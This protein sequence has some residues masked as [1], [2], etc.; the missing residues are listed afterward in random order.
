MTKNQSVVGLYIRVSTQEQ[1]REGYSIEEQKER[2]T[3]YAEAHSWIIGDVYSDPGFSGAKLERPSI[4]RLITDAEEH[5]I[6][7]VIVYKLDRL[8]RS[9]K[10]TLYLIEDVF[11]KNGVDFVSMTE[12]FDTGTPFGKAMIG[13]LSEFAQLER[14]QIK[15]RLTMGRVGRAKSGLVLGNFNTIT[16]YDYV[17]G[18]LVVNEYYTEI[19]RRIF[20][21]FVAGRS[22]NAVARDLNA[23]NIPTPSGYEWRGGNLGHLLQHRAYIGEVEYRGEVYPGEHEAI[24][25]RETFNAAQDRLEDRRLNDELYHRFSSRSSILTGLCWCTHCRAKKEILSGRKADGTRT[26]FIGCREKKKKNCPDERIPLEMVEEYVLTEIKKLRLDPE[27][28]KD[29]RKKSEAK[30]VK[31]QI[32]IYEERIAENEKK[33]KRLTDL[34]VVEG[35]DLA[36]LK[37]RVEQCTAENESNRERI[38]RLRRSLKEEIP[39]EKILDLVDLLDDSDEETVKAAVKALIKRI[40]FSGNTITINWTF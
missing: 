23:E 7:K 40:D 21:E 3:K 2:L 19:V 38:Q 16:G 36:T 25:D 17:D 30:P 10:D 11:L 14:E 6:D 37:E 28:L 15:E 34:Y 5:K 33:V 20:R 22:L 13:I 9:Q 12:N 4:R 31:D 27:C 1:A 29:S 18:K 8:S 26:R 39:D 24:I 32:R 35:I